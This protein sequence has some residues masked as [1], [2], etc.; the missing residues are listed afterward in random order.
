MLKCLNFRYWVVGLW[1]VLGP[2]FACAEPSDKPLILTSI[3]P[4][5]LIAEDVVGELFA[6]EALLGTGTDPHNATLRYSQR[7]KLS[8]AGV[9]VWLGSDFERFLDKSVARLPP[10]HQLR[11]ETLPGIHWAEFAQAHQHGSAADQHLLKDMHLWLNPQNALVVAQ[12]LV[13][14]LADRYPARKTDLAQRLEVVTADWRA[15]DSE[16]EDRFE[17]LRS[18]PFGVYHNAYTHFVA[19]YKLN[20]VAAI[21]QFP[22]QGLSAHHLAEFVTAM[23]GAHCLVAESKGRSAER[24]AERL[25]LPLVVA[26]PL[27]NDSGISSYRTFMEEIAAAFQQCLATSQQMQR[28]G[29]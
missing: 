6:V 11:V 5:A 1:A 18:V 22:E 9:V 28:V 4:L 27:A 3:R 23:Q 8:E 15:L 26:D 17:S 20:M 29:Q 10:N 12:A 25:G 2:V 19:R 7:K 13:A 24:L 21:N 16:L 14:T